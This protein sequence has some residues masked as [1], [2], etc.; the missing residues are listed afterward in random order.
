[1]KR[2]NKRKMQGVQAVIWSCRK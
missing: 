1:M 2:E